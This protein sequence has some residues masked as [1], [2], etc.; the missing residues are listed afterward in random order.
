MSDGYTVLMSS[1]LQMSRTFSH[2]GQTLST[3]ESDAKVNA[4]DT[5]GSA[6]NAALSTALQVAGLTTGQFSAMVTD[7]GKKLDA[8]YQKYREAEES[9][10]QLCHDLAILITGK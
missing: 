3:V 7:H 1:L 4:P 2:E 6:S 8:A 10:V 9:S 5:G